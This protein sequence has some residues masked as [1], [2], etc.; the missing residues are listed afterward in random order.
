MDTSDFLCMLIS[1]LPG[2]T[3]DRS[4]KRALII[5]RQH[6]RKPEL[7]DSIDFLTMKFSWFSL[8]IHCFPE[9]H[10]GTILRRLIKLATIREESSRMWEKQNWKR[11]VLMQKMVPVNS[12][13]YNVQFVMKAMILT[14]A[15][16]SM[17]K[18]PRREAK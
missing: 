5:R 13:N 14:T 4:N 7:E 18:R 17:I 16:C 15:V 1:K 3:R 12:R 6:R 11:N 9:R 2:N 10:W 8:M